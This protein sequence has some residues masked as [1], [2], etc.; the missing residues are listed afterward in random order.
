M[1]VCKQLTG[2]ECH[3]TTFGVFWIERG[4]TKVRYGAAAA[5]DY[6]KPLL[7]ARLTVEQ[8][9]HMVV[10]AYLKQLYGTE[11]AVHVKSPQELRFL[12]MCMESDFEGYS[13]YGN[14]KPKTSPTRENNFVV[15]LDDSKYLMFGT[16]ERSINRPHSMSYSEMLIGTKVKSEEAKNSNF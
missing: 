13:W 2:V 3:G 14:S 5:Q 6:D 12:E 16:S 11:L 9:S 8:F 7:I 1:K 15:F 10:R 4:S